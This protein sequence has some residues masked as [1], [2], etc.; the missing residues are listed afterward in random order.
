MTRHVLVITLLALAT[1]ARADKAAAEAAFD[2]AAALA[3]S[4]NFRD[5]CP[6]FETSYKADPQ[7]GVLLNLADCHEH[8][9][10]T[11]T[12]WVEFNDAV[13]L[14]SSLGDN[15]EAYARRRA[16]GLA[17][18]LSRLRVIGPSPPIAG[19][20]VR[21]DDADISVLIGKDM[22]LDPG[23]H[24][25]SATAQGYVPWSTKLVIADT[26]KTTELT[27]PA[28][29][30]ASV[31]K[32]QGTL[33]ITA[34][35]DA[36]ISIDSAPVGQSGRFEGRLDAGPHAL[37]VTAPGKR[38]EQ[39]DV[40]VVENDAR[41][42]DVTLDALGVPEVPTRVPAT[43]LLVV[44][45]GGYSFVK[46]LDTSQCNASV[47]PALGGAGSLTL[48]LRRRLGGNFD[49]T[50]SLGVGIG[51]SVS[52]GSASNCI[53]I[54]SGDFFA[55]PLA[56]LIRVRPGAWF[57]GLGPQVAVVSQDLSGSQMGSGGPSS[58]RVPLEQ[59]VTS[60]EVG[61]VLEFGRTFGP[62][63]L[64]EAGLRIELAGAPSHYLENGTTT[65]AIVGLSVGYAF[66]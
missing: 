49:F 32:P 44:A 39:R 25:V 1:P 42:I 9:G 12:A 5:A 63:E 13:Q 27:I 66:R 56:A 38:T 37:R 16:D 14:A 58:P 18:K 40:I 21:R 54:S 8:V 48:A 22:P 2:Q 31:S 17:P 65:Y 24:Q 26:A 35:S 64:W 50:A 51:P 36:E 34:P 6:L 23:E 46:T 41:T 47:V 10:R 53:Y 30:P 28:L 11:A 29:T 4:G 15:R 7:L 43:R 19:L 60:F 59:S 45:G 62:H 57:I 3:S 52:G 55:F 61:G 20:V 33:V